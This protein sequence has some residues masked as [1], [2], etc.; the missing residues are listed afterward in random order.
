MYYGGPTGIFRIVCKDGKYYEPEYMNDQINMP[1]YLNWT[2]FIA[3]DESYLIFSRHINKGD[4]FIAFH[5]TLADVW[6]K[7]IDMG[8]RIN[9]SGQERFPSISPDGKYMFFTRSDG[10]NQH[11]VYWVSSKIIENI[12][13]EVLNSKVTK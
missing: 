1:G 8:D 5:D 13:K 3:P 10:N 9:T 6:T 2:P 12:K 7:P 4:L 11:D